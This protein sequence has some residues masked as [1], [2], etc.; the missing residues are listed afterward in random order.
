MSKVS[1]IIPARHEIFLKQ[2]C[3]DILARAT[4][5]IE[6][7][8]VLDGYWAFEPLPE[9]PRLTIIHRERKGMRAAINSGVALAK[10]K[11]LMKVDGHCMFAQ[12]FD[13][14]LK[15]EC[16]KDWIVIPRRYS[17]DAETWSIR[18]HKD[19]V[20]YEYLSWPWRYDHPKDG[21]GGMGLHGMTWD[22]RI[23]SRID[24]LLDE[25]LTFQGSCWFMPKEFFNRRIVRMDDEEQHYGTFI[26]EAQE[27]GL[28]AWLGGGKVMV[29]KKTWY[30]HLWKGEPYRAKFKELMG[31][32]YSRIGFN[33]RKNGNMYSIHYWLNNLWEGRKHN[34]DWLIDRFTPVPSWP[35]DKGKWIPST[36]S[37]TNST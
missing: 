8:V 22:E 36:T 12:G 17:L 29:N 10:G 37:S 11:Y 25:T 6:L 13:E 19:F 2:T 35:K 21:V 14:V 31:E 27:L 3:A 23:V 15:A 33:E 30:A 32:R 9:D 5:D 1:I 26:G 16:D 24:R 18:A 34:L 7:L 4:G 20:D 28:K